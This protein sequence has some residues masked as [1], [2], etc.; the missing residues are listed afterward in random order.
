MAVWWGSV[1]EC[2]SALTRL[3]REGAIDRTG[4]ATAFEFLRV[5]EREWFQIEPSEGLREQAC[6]L[7]RAHP[8]RA[9]DAL[10]LAS[11]LRLANDRGEL[12]SM[13]CYDRRLADA[14]RA[15]RIPVIGAIA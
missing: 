4:V 7:L 11:A 10:V 13:V 2:T 1:V 5:I 3:L 6:L 9:S 12:P 15:E 14:A 8:L